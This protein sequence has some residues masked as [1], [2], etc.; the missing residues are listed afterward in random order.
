M[1]PK[2]TVSKTTLSP[3]RVEFVARTAASPYPERGLVVVRHHG[4][5]IVDWAYV[6]LWVPASEATL[7]KTILASFAFN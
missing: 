4:S 5:T 1:A 2:G 3:W 6:Q 7:A